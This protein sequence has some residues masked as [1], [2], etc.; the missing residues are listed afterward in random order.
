[1]DEKRK[2]TIALN[3]N[4]RVEDII[5]APNTENIYDAVLNFEKEGLSDRLLE[6]LGIAPRRKDLKEWKR[7]IM[8]GRRATKPVRIGM[9]GKYFGSGS[10]VLTD[11]YISVIEAVRHAA[12]AAGRKPVIEWINAE[13]FEKKS[14][15]VGVLKKYDGI[16][17]P[18][19]FGA[20]GVEGIISAI[21][22]CRERKIPYLGL[23]YGMQ[24]AVVE[25]ARNVVGLK[26]GNT[27]E[28]DK[29]TPHPVIDIMPEQKKKSPTRITARRCVWGLPC[30]FK[31]HT[32][33]LAAYKSHLIS[34][35]HR[36]RYEVNPEYIKR[37]EEK[38]LVFSGTSPDKRLM[39]IAELP[40]SKHPFF[41]E[42]NFI[43][44][45]SRGRSSRTPCS[46]NS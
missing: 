32:I 25:F 23:C 5:S 8:A 24:L 42:P 18:G 28:I 31:E 3:G 2:Q 10:F 27:T 39:E 13:E 33:A 30:A 7:F 6:K 44:S 45:S 4:L 41:L 36:H 21:R 16:I 29:D 40:K 43:R 22:Y 38:G 14:A 35:R 20:R 17:V 19:G 9:V 1:M 26:R 37:L 15:A 11:S 12:Y 34:E 46:G